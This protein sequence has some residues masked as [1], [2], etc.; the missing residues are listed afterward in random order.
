MKDA[1][2]YVRHIL[3]S[4]RRVEEYTRTGRKAFDA[5]TQ[6]Q[7]AVIRNLEII[8]EAAKQAPDSLRRKHPKIPWK[9]MAGMRDKLI[10]H[11]FGV[12]LALV[13]VVVEKDIPLMLARM[14]AILRAEASE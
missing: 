1:L 11:Y 8:G 2:V 3:D 13:W 7:D 12:D 6:I 14:D 9:G 10:H 5:S 4:A